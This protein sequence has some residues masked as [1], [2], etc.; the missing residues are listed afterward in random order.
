MFKMVFKDPVH[1]RE[2]SRNLVTKRATLTATLRPFLP[3]YESVN[4]MAS[5]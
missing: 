1:A 4:L 3:W 5:K 2:Y